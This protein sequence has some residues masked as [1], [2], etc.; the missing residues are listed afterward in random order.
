M[1]T[2]LLTFLQVLALARTNREINDSTIE[3]S[4]SSIA[5]A[6]SASKLIC[7]LKCFTVVAIFHQM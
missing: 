4:P 5:L 2:L 6:N 7:H 3:E 1:M